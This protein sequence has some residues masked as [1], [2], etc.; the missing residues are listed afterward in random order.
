MKLAIIKLFPYCRLDNAKDGLDLLGI[1]I[2][3][4][5]QKVSWLGKKSAVH[6]YTHTQSY[7]M[8]H[9]QACF[10]VCFILSLYMLQ[11]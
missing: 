8:W 9:N 3:F 2:Y 1:R 7:L 4:L 11:V 5:I 10:D 6:F